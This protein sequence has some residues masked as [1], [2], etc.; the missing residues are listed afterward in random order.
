MN[1]E[2]A[3]FNMIE[4]Q[5]KP[6]KVFDENLLGAMATIPREKF[7]PESH[8]NLAYADMPVP[9]GHNQQMLTPREIARLIQALELE[10]SEKVLEIGCGSGYSSALLSRLAKKIY[11]VDI[12]GDFIDS[13]RKTLKKLAFSNVELEETDA[14]DSWLS[15]APYDAILI[16]SALPHLTDSF[17]K[18][19]SSS[20]RIAAIIGTDGQYSAQICRLDEKEEWVC[21][22]LFPVEAI[23]MI[24]V[25]QPNKFK[26]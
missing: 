25:E 8:R 20:G 9:I 23:P 12:I 16:T 10:G 7:V 21:E 18:S 24:N 15:K 22:E 4:Q 5:V 2:K 26:F 3:R 13:A 1:L 19:L 14:S 11:S 6:W 17:K